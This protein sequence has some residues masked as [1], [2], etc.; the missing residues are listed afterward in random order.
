MTQAYVVG[1]CGLVCL[2]WSTGDQWW[3]ATVLLFGPRWPILAPLLLLAPLGLAFRRHVLPWLFGVLILAVGPFMG[4]ALPW[5]RVSGF[6]ADAPDLTMRLVTY[7]CGDTGD[8]AVIQMA[9]ALQPDILTLNEWHASRPLPDALTAGRQIA[10]AEGNV[11]L[12]RFPIE[13][14]ERLQSD[15]LKPWELRALRC[16]LRTSAG[17]IQIVCLHLETPRQGLDEVRNSL[18][19]GPEAIRRNT[20]KRRFEAELVSGFAEEFSGPA[21]VAGDFNTPVESRIYRRYWS[22]WQNA[23]SQ[24]G[25][26]LGYTK[27]TRLFG[28]RIDHILVNSHW[29]VTSAWVGHELGGDHRPVVA[30]LALRL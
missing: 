15:R 26:G 23:F 18:L 10:R 16:L 5:Q 22:D 7:N 29:R 3:L 4:M 8:E 21:I 27:F 25:F 11:V 13:D 1:V 17:P 12:S 28:A 20:E 6:F 2:L 19:R 14:I 24:A 30:E 9:R